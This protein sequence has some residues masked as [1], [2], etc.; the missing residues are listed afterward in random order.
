MTLCEICEEVEGTI[1]LHNVDGWTCMMVCEGC[2]EKYYGELQD[3]GI[4][5]SPGPARKEKDQK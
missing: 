5:L 1:D 3:E 4:A 2:F